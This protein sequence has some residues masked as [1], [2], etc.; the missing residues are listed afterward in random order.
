MRLADV[1]AIVESLSINPEECPGCPEPEWLEELC[2]ILDSAPTV[3]AVEEVW[4]MESRWNCPLWLLLL[5]RKEK[6]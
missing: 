4:D 6:R 2:L 5:G 1:D 3:D